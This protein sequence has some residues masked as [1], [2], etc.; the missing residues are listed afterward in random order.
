MIQHYRHGCI[1]DINILPYLEATMESSSLAI[2]S[3]TKV[4]KKG[5]STKQFKSAIEYRSSKKTENNH[6]KDQL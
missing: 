3:C 5:R 6:R 2:K 4:S 1:L